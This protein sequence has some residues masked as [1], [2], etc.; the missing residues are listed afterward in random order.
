[1][2]YKDISYKYLFPRGSKHTPK[3]ILC[4]LH[5]V[6]IG[7]KVKSQNT[8]GHDHPYGSCSRTGCV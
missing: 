2:Q 1:M 8:Y 3:D 5:D 4:A 6:K 7:S